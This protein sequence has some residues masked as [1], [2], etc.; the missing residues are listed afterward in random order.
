MAKRKCTLEY[1]DKPHFGKGFCSG[2]YYQLNR[3]G[4]NLL[5][6]KPLKNRRWGEKTLCKFEG[7]AREYSSK[8]YCRYH[9]NQLSSG[10]DLTPVTKVYKK[11]EL[12][13]PSYNPDS[14][15]FK[16]WDKI[17]LEN[18]DLH[19]DYEKSLKKRFLMFRDKSRLGEMNE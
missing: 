11:R 8:G 6:L 17:R 18:P 12:K 9:Y 13:K 19:S 1:C 7:C 15:I 4:G 16:E 14:Y 5:A 3:S 10:V 2:H